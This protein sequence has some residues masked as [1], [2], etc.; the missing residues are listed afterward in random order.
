MGFWNGIF[1]KAKGW[2]FTPVK[3]NGQWYTPLGKLVKNPNAYWTAI[4]RNGRF[5]NGIFDKAK[6]RRVTPV[7][8]NGQWYTPLGKLVKNPD[9]YWA[10]IKRNGKFWRSKG[11]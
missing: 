7:K 3:I 1:D 9:A 10:A 8:I 4:K 5:W 11:K 2:R 6:G